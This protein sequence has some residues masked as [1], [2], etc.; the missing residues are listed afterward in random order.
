MPP[1]PLTN[2][3]S[4]NLQAGLPQFSV[5]LIELVE[6]DQNGQATWSLQGEPGFR[7]VVE[8]STGGVVRTWTPF[9]V[10]TNQTGEVFFTDST[11]A[12]SLQLYR[13]RILD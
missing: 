13:A 2:L 11:Q 8:R 12:E 10:L 5:G 6:E 3:V 7:Y 1:A 4:F 9:V